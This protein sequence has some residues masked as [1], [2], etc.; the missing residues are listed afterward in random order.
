MKKFLHSTYLPV[1]VPLAAI[2]ALALR[3]WT[4]GGGPDG[5]GLYAPQPLGWALLWL[6]TAAALAS[7]YYLTRGL[8]NPGR[9]SENFPASILGAAGCLAG[10]L[11]IAASALPTFATTTGNMLTLLAAL[12]GVIST[13]SLLLTAFIRYRGGKPHFLLHAIPC[14]YFALRIFNCCR[15]WSNVTQIS[16]FLFQFLASICVML[17]TYQMC[18]FDVNIGDR[19][20]SLLWSFSGIYFC[21]LALPMGEDIW[22]Y[23]GMLLWLM[24]NLCALRPLK[25]NRPVQENE[26]APQPD[27]TPLTPEE[28][29]TDN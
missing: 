22:F 19:R 6:V 1:L 18:C 21:V 16:E 20:S 7:I 14:L 25:A 15:T 10:G 24:L 12:L 2:L 8:K 9:Y 17:A 27:I 23:A 26:P 13:L 29:E 3:L 5:E 4:L 28:E 11:G